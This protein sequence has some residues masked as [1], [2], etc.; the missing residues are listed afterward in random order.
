MFGAATTVN[1]NPLLSMPPTLTT[2]L[3][4]VAP[5]GMV[6]TILVAF[7]VVIVATVPLKFTV[8]LP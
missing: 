3:P 8:L 2:A 5:L 1:L 7:H 4:V 6:T